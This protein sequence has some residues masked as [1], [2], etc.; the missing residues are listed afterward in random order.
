MK[1]AVFIA[2][3]VVF[4]LSSQLQAQTSKTKVSK[5]DKVMTKETIYQFKVQDLSGDP[6]DFASLKG[7]KILIVNT[8]S[9]CGLTP[10]YKDLEAVYKEYKDKGFVI[11]GFP[12]NNFASQ[13]PGTNKEIETFCQQNY[14]VTFPMMD[15]VSVKGDDM[16]DVYKFLTQK[17]K[18]GLQDSEV[19]WNFQKYLINE[20]GE[21]VKVI[22]PKTLVT[23]P[24]VINWIKS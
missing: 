16:C 7:K 3:S 22:K 14:G 15:K 17:S 2:C 10:Q 19:E 6:F 9:K 4:F 1:K 12:A 21:L 23:E 13:E 20:K 18:N 24:E 11:V 8:A 5:T